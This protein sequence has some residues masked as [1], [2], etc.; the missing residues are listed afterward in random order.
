MHKIIPL[1]VIA[2]ADDF[3]FDKLL[4]DGCILAFERGYINSISIM[5]NTDYFN[6]AVSVLKKYPSLRNIGIHVNFTAGKPLTNMDKRFLTSE[7]EWN[8]TVI[9]KSYTI[10]DKRARAA[11][12]KELCCQIEQALKVGINVNHLNSH[13]HVHILPCFTGMFMKAASNYGLKL[14]LAQTN[15]SGNF[16]KNL[17]RRKL[18]AIIVS[19]DLHYANYFEYPYSSNKKN[20]SVNNIETIEF[21]FH[22]TFDEF[23]ELTDHYD[24]I[25][26]NRWAQCFTDPVSEKIAIIKDGALCHYSIAGF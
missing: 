1:N 6:E 4:T 25:S 26:F 8:P 9:N 20:Q 5:T 14:R 23:G 15:S 17:Y 13:H 22:P 16:L 2:N 3:G 7:G 19:K 12:Y 18:N 21:M 10:L 24:P 11:F